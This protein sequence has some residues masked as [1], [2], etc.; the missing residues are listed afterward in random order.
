MTRSQ[1]ESSSSEWEVE[2]GVEREVPIADDVDLLF[3]NYLDQLKVIGQFPE[4]S[5]ETREACRY[6][7]QEDLFSAVGKLDNVNKALEKVNY[8]LQR[9]RSTDLNPQ[10]LQEVQRLK[11]EQQLQLEGSSVKLIEERIQALDH[12]ATETSAEG[13]EDPQPNPGDDKK[14]NIEPE[15]DLVQLFDITEDGETIFNKG[16]LDDL[17]DQIG[18]RP[19]SIISTA[20]KF[21]QGKTFW[22]NVLL[23]G[24]QQGKADF[25]PTD[26]IGGHD[27]IRFK[28]GHIRHTKGI[29]VWPKVFIRK[30]NEGKE[31]AVI[32]MDTQGTFDTT[33]NMIDS[34]IIFS[35]SLLMSSIKIFN[36]RTRIDAQDLDS[37]NLFL[38]FSQRTDERAGQHFIIMIRDALESGYQPSYIETLQTQTK[39]VAELNKLFEG[40]F[41]A[42]EKVECFM[43]KTPSEHVMSANGE[44]RAQDCG[45]QFLGDLCECA[46]HVLENLV[47]KKFMGN[48]LTGNTLKQYVE[49]L[50][51]HIKE[52]NHKAIG[53]AFQATSEL[54]F[55]K[56]KAAAAEYFAAAHDQLM[57]GSGH[58]PIN[59]KVYEK[60]LKKFVDEALQEYSSKPLFGTQEAK[61]KTFLALKESL[62]EKCQEKL[63]SN[64]SRFRDFLMADAVH[65]SSELYEKGMKPDFGDSLLGKATVEQ[66]KA[67][68]EK[69]FPEAMS[70]FENAVAPFNDEVDLIDSKRNLLT[71]MLLTRFED[72]QSD[73]LVVQLN[74]SLDSMINA[75]ADNYEKH[76]KEQVPLVKKLDD[77]G[78]F[79]ERGIN[80]LNTSFEANKAQFIIDISQLMPKLDLNMLRQMIDNYKDAKGALFKRC[81]DHFESAVRAHFSM[82]KLRN[83]MID[84]RH[85]QNE[86]QKKLQAQQGRIQEQ[87]TDTQQQL[88][89]EKRKREAAEKSSDLN[90]IVLLLKQMN[91]QTQQ[92]LEN[93]RE[94]R[95][96]KE[97]REA[98]EETN[99]L[100]REWNE[101]RMRMEQQRADNKK[102]E[103]N[104]K[105]D[106]KERDA[107][108]DRKEEK[109]RNEQS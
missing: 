24:L 78:M 83:K 66:V 20:G 25:K 14:P 91:E 18:D 106:R 74:T 33:S 99:R 104:R 15:T 97:M 63:R 30:D 86:A 3:G 79:I 108:R 55:E 87:L 93:A 82:E 1:S 57:R 39:R 2:N 35:I 23:K 51:D 7:A 69:A 44:I 40:I 68:H 102:E 105:E 21:R 60:T 101:A 67:R 6:Q 31:L 47:P 13:N 65:Q 107:E 17:C 22:N 64:R 11:L 94:E 59:P 36:V 4:E 9:K 5:D 28:S 19:V 32:L 37:L 72:L 81:E 41:S 12:T 29:M 95:Q 58:Q 42:F 16:V 71:K 76:L 54:F 96:R 10:I 52:N 50:V 27:G 75:H 26:Y 100:E 48:H 103:R 77:I 98:Q 80:A 49:N 56:A 53:S 84:M 92:Q 88:D 46:N 62:E 34:A 38:A 73:N 8:L 85:R 61:G 109:D 45:D 43:A 70:L 89:E 90:P